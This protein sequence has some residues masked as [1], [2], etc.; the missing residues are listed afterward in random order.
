MLV[1]YFTSVIQC[2]RFKPLLFAISYILVILPCLSCTLVVA[3]DN[4]SVDV[5]QAGGVKKSDKPAPLKVNRISAH[6]L[7]ARS[8]EFSE[9]I[10]GADRLALGNVV[11]GEQASQSTFV[12]VEIGLTNT[13]PR[14]VR[15]DVQFIAREVGTQKVIVNKTVTASYFNRDKNTYLGFFLHDTGCDAIELIV[16]FP[17]FPQLAAV[18][19]HLDFACYE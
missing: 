17:E 1:S 5:A 12:K 2:S 16:S 19:E 6:L 14:S 13:A 3:S 11:I 8:G 9:N 18:T 15:A 10:L 4:T 7:Y